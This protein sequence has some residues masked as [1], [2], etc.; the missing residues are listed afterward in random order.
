MLVAAFSFAFALLRARR[1]FCAVLRVSGEAYQESAG[2]FRPAPAEHR[3]A[4]R[5]FPFQVDG[6]AIVPCVA[7]GRF[8]HGGLPGKRKSGRP[9][10]TKMRGQRRHVAPLRILRCSV[11]GLFGSVGCRPADLWVCGMFPPFIPLL[12]WVSSVALSCCPRRFRCS[13]FPSISPLPPL[14]ASGCCQSVAPGCSVA[15]WVVGLW[16]A[17]PVCSVDPVGAPLLSVVAPCCSFAPLP[18]WFLRCPRLWLPVVPLLTGV[19]P[20]CSVAPVGAPSLP[21]VAFGC[22]SPIAPVGCCSVDPGCCP[23][24]HPPLLPDKQ[25]KKT[26]KKTTGKENRKK[27]LRTEI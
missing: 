23:R 12:L 25:Q 26:E 9:K 6:S 2:R 27:R 21:V 3:C 8:G 10:K 22:C 15:P 19:A 14:V 16:V 1:P 11:L 24:L 4:V 18:L 5:R 17:A 13:V 20:G 7:S